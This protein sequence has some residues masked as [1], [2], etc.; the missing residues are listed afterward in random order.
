MRS[1]LLLC[2]R[3]APLALSLGLL[4]CTRVDWVPLEGAVEPYA[5]P[6]MSVSGRLCA[7]APEAV[8]YPL[9]L[10]FL[11]DGSE[12]MEVSDPPDPDTGL[13]RRQVAVR[14][15]WER[16][17]E[18][19]RASGEVRVGLI[20]F[21]AQAQPLTQEDSDG[22][23]V[24]DTLFTSDPRALEV[25]TD[26][27][28]FTDRTTNYLNALDAAYVALRAEALRA[29]GE[30]LGRSRFVVIFISDGLP[31]DGASGAQGSMSEQVSAKITDLRRLESLFGVGEVQLHTLFVSSAQGLSL[32]EEAQ[33]LLLAMAEVGGGTYRSA[34]SGEGLSFL[35]I[36]LSSLRRL[37]SLKSFVPLATHLTQRDAQRPAQVEAAWDAGRFLDADQDGAPSCGEPML[38][39]DGDG[40]AD[41]FE[42]RI[43]A[44][45]LLA[46]TDGDHLSDLVEWEMRRSGLD[47]LDLAGAV[48]DTLD[49]DTDGDGL[50]D[51]EE[52]FLGSSATRVDSD[53]D[54]LPDPVEARLGL[55]AQQAEGSGDLDW[56]GTGNA[57]EALNGFD[58]LCD[59]A[60]VRSRVGYARALEEREALE[61]GRPCYDFTVEGVPLSDTLVDPLLS[62]PTP[63]G[64]RLTLYAG[65]GAFDERS[66][67][68]LWRAACVRA[69]ALSALPS[70]TSSA[71][72]GEPRYTVTLS[73]ADFHPLTALTEEQCR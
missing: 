29:S 7:S 59:D 34:P 6:T 9:R 41:L 10:L 50:N 53:D 17:L 23:G 31:S 20:R 47:P 66:N 58:P 68:S 33:S 13:R 24:P 2:E 61:E 1:P 21:S 42:R 15:A 25:A 40:L 72:E 57:V 73:D 48:C 30:A 71:R 70:P 18:Q 22:D 55:S 11:V 63:Q 36:S 37:Y 69:P 56:D 65:E 4:S 60:S 52:L 49:L 45:P 28:S 8:E 54:G 27:L 51:C 16:V 3:L 19:S 39:S 46:D 26:K 64:A 32:D 12:S 14:E 62:S 44:D 5:P 38:D 67:V 35:H 43:G